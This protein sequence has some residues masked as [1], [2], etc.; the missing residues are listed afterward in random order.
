MSPRVAVITCACLLG[1]CFQARGGVGDAS[2]PHVEDKGRYDYSL[3]AASTAHRAFAIAPGGGWGW[4]ADADS[5]E[6]AAEAALAACQ[7]HTAQ[8]CVLYAVDD[9]VVFDAKAWPTLWGPYKLRD[10]AGRAATG[11]GRGERF[12]DLRFRDV[13]GRTMDLSSLRGRV[14]VLHFWGSWCGPCRKEMPEL[15]ALGE[16]LKD[17]GDVSFVLLQVRETFDVARRWV[18]QQGIRLPLFDS[19]S[20]G[21][22]D[23]AFTLADGATLKDRDIAGR[24]PTT[25]VLDKHGVVLFAHVGPVARWSEYAAFLRDAAVKSGR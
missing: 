1:T 20:R 4:K 11:R 12:P 15:Q 2:P 7:R 21:E 22:S 8:R 13:T 6:Q 10:E 9:D 16:S 23:D 17:R 19:G 18:A 24:F 5:R 25:Y 14:V 3:F